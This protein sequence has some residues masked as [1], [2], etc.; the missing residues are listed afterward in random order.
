MLRRASVVLPSLVLLSIVV[1]PGDARTQ[2][3]PDPVAAGARLFEAG[4]LPEAREALLAAEREGVRDALLHYH[5]G[6]VALAEGGYGKAGDWIE[7]ATKA[8]PERAEHHYWRG[9]AAG[10]AAMRAN[11]IRQAVLARRVKSAFERAIELDSTYV[12]ARLGLVRFHLQAPGAM[13]G[14]KDRARAEAAIVAELSPWSG[15]LAWTMVY[16]AERDTASY[17]R[18]QRDAI[19]AFPDSTRP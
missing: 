14:S 12:D 2:G 5:L 17:A 4:R 1:L 11:P 18:V 15:Y 6:R 9:R 16:E 7:K 8:D 10:A 13:G 19:D 3:V